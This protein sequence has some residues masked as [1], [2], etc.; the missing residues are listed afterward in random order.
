MRHTG[1]GR[2]LQIVR[3]QPVVGGPDVLLEE[4]PVA[5]GQPVQ[6][7]QVPGRWCEHAANLRAAEPPGQRRAEQPEC[8]NRRCHQQGRGLQRQ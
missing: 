4:R 2:F 7:A 1:I 8:E 5:P 3:W 6:K